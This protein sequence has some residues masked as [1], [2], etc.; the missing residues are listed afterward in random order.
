MSCLWKSTFERETARLLRVL[1]L[2]P[3]KAKI[4]KT[5]DD[6]E[7]IER[8]GWK[9]AVP[10]KTQGFARNFYIPEGEK[11]QIL[12]Q[13]NNTFF[14]ISLLRGSIHALC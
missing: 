13:V 7:P 14:C 6:S 2:S 12:F 11:T 9:A 4:Q 10:G 3:T 8:A 1:P 5:N